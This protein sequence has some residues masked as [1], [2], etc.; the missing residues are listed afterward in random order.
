MEAVRKKMRMRS[1][2]GLA[3]VAAGVLFV[4]VLAFAFVSETVLPFTDHL[5]QD[6]LAGDGEHTVRFFQDDEEDKV[7]SVYVRHGR[8]EEYLYRMIVEVWHRENTILDSLSL[9]FNTVRPASAL[10]LETPEGYPWPPF[11]LGPGRDDVTGGVVVN[12]PDLEFQGIGTVRLVF[13][14]RTDVLTPAP[15][16]ELRL[17]VAFSMHKDGLPKLTKQEGETTIL[18]ELA[19]RSTAAVAFEELFSDPGQYN[20]KDIIL[21]G[22]YFDGW[23]TTVLSERMEYTGQA[24]GHLWPRGRMVWIENNL[25]PTEVYDQLYQQEMIGPLERYGK[26]RIRG[27]F[28]HGER[29]G[30]G[31]GFTAQI[32]LSEVELLPWSP[33]PQRPDLSLTDLKYRLIEHFGGV[34]VPEPAMV[35]DDVRREQASSAFATIQTNDEEFQ[36][37][38][39]K[40]GLSEATSFTEE[41]QLL[42]FE[43]KKK[44]NAVR[45]EPTDSGYTFGLTVREEGDPFE[46]SGVVEQK[47]K[48]TVLTKEHALLPN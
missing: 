20:G 47:G 44:L 46:I 29:Y 2:V 5:R 15:P 19:R 37:V 8:A 6:A 45:L 7:A 39:R 31:G 42:V 30:H 4:L 21:T 25:M 16:E 33:A 11:E 13:Y 9:K 26:L 10:W 1:K 14:L 23:E 12:I 35:P 36:A 18:L 38:L 34:L 40:L 24:E 41:Q 27:R 17:D 32:V 48:I 3:A 28:E 22:F 43:E